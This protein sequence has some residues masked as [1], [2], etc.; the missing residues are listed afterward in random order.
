MKE[1]ITGIAAGG[2]ALLGT[3]VQTVPIDPSGWTGFLKEGGA[4]LCTVIAI[5]YLLKE[6]SSM[7]A[8]HQS[9]LDKKD[10]QIEALEEKIDALEERLEA[11]GHLLAKTIS[12]ID[13]SATV[14]RESLEMEKQNG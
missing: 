9:Q 1:I 8:E 7:K 5:V 6:K 13:V 4:L 14:K 10:R 3:V 2:M 11:Q 12:Q